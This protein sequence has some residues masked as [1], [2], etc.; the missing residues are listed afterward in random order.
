MVGG[1]TLAG[2]AVLTRREQHEQSKLRTDEALTGTRGAGH[3]QVSHGV[4]CGVNPPETAAA[5]PSAGRDGLKSET[6][7]TH[8]W[9]FSAL[10]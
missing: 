4:G 10:H 9:S 1:L 7:Q 8:T 5:R 3:G 2:D 6:A